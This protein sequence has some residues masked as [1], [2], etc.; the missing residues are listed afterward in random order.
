M[1]F[2]PTELLVLTL[3][4]GDVVVVEGGAGFGRSAHIARALQGWGFQNSIIRIRPRPGLSSGRYLDYAIQSSL[5]NGSIALDAST[6]TIPH[7]TAEKV[8]AH[9]I[10]VHS[11]ARQVTIA[12]FL[13]RE[14][15]KIDALIEKQN[16]LIALLHERRWSVSEL[17]V[18]QSQKWQSPLGPSC[19][20][21]QTGPFGSQL[22]AEDYVDDG[23][24]VINPQHLARGIIKADHAVSV[25]A[26]TAERL[27]RHRLQPNDV[28][29]ARR[30]ELGRCAVVRSEHA[31]WLCGTG[32]IVV[33][34]LQGQWN[35][36]FLQ[37]VLSSRKTS[38]A[39]EQNSVG[40]TM[41]NLNSSMLARLRMP[42]PSKAEQDKQIN[43]HQQRIGKIDALIAKAEEHIALAQERRAAL[44]TAAVT[45]QLDIPGAD[46]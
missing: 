27:S 34:P 29:V 26:A 33:R 10:P 44:I 39:L 5:S 25:D 28:V 13:D 9:R 46:R 8:A 14:T 12:D 45:G 37:A 42:K 7:F 40:S 35:S 1:W 31:G 15:A 20:L 17:L 23:T 4:P 36:D 6:A 21:I 16:E 24:P 43:E 19:S 3:Q 18:E 30:G 2:H 38:D 22:K 32:S 41:P 11:L